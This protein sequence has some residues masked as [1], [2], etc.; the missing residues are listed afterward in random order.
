MKIIIYLNQMPNNTEENSFKKMSLSMGNRVLIE[1]ALSLKCEINDSVTAV[2]VGDKKF[3]ILLREAMARGCDQAVL[4]E[5]PI[6]TYPLSF[7]ISVLL[8]KI[9]FDVILTGYRTLD[10]NTS[11][12]GSQIAERLQLLQVSFVNQIEKDG[13]VLLVHRQITD[14]TQVIRITPPCMLTVLDKK[15]C[16]G[17]LSVND[18]NKASEK[19][20]LFWNIHDNEKMID[21]FLYKREW[22]KLRVVEKTTKNILSNYEIINCIS[23]EENDEVKLVNEAVDAIIYRLQE[24]S[25]IRIR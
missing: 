11:Y 19:E 16:N 5:E 7:V 24:R 15:V 1:E 18:I 23:N 2:L 25:L 13:N 12:I 8:K 9:K 6:K 17:V 10:E 20:I 4:V 14:K 22:P 3:Q 21:S